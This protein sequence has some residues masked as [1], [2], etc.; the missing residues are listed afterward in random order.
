MA[1]SSPLGVWYNGVSLNGKR[2]LSFTPDL[3]RGQRENSPDDYVAC[4]QCLGCRLDHA[5]MWQGRCLM[6]MQDHENTFFLTLTYDNE[7]L[8]IQSR[9]CHEF[10]DESTGEV[11]SVPVST[12]S[13]DDVQKWKKR[14]AK[15]WSKR[16][17]KPLRFYGCGEYGDTTMRPHY[18]FLVFGLDLDENELTYYKQSTAGKINSTLYNCEWINKTWGKGH[19][20]IGR[21]TYESA[22]YIARY[23]LKKRGAVDKQLYLDNGLT[24]PFINMSRR[25]GIGLPYLERVSEVIV[26][27]DDIDDIHIS[28]AKGG[29]TVRISG[30]MLDKLS[31][32]Y[33]EIVEK[34]KDKRKEAMEI[35]R[36]A[37]KS[38]T[39]I[40][41]PLYL[42]N[43]GLALESRTKALQ[44]RG[45]VDD[46]EGA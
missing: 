17:D 22:G 7:H 32:V 2:V 31:A 38:S 39:D 36:A 37:I 3:S 23:V 33:P 25:P 5:K 34:V 44:M 42:Y 43:Q 35:K 30:Y 13:L 29:K 41:Y 20:V 6:E 27:D 1:C 16:S 14:L 15:A 11:K 40:P 8:P 45:G 10:V 12:L 21:G 46:M 4:G 9:Y 18:H 28:T 26:S 24:P 19:V